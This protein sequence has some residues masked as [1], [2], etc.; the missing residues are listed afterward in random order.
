MSRRERFLYEYL[1]SV[2]PDAQEI[3]SMSP[4]DLGAVLLGYVHEQTGGRTGVLASL[5]YESE[6]GEYP[7]H[8]RPMLVRAVA[9]ARSW[10]DREGLVMR[11]PGQAESYVELTDQGAKLADPEAVEAFRQSRLLPKALLHAD[12][13]RLAWA[14]FRRG[15][16][17]DAVFA[18]F[19][20]VEIAVRAKGSF[21]AETVGT[22]LMS[23]AF[24]PMGGPL[25][26]AS[27]PAAEREGLRSLFVGAIGLYKNPQSHRAVGIS[28]VQQAIDL[29]LFASHLLRIVDA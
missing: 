5:W 4:E 3:A 12:V 19:R 7:S 14:D 11:A 13:A 17:D 29:L 15:S 6:F 22:R 25:T 23:E 8:H 9:Q 27:L 28:N 2:L 16:Y 18:A 24:N 26:D 21:P 10:L 1:Y 20:Q